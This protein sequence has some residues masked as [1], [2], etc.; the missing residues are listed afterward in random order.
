MYEDQAPTLVRVVRLVI[1]EAWSAIFPILPVLESHHLFGHVHLHWIT[2]GQRQQPRSSR[3]SSGRAR[4]GSDLTTIRGK[5]T[6]AS[7]FGLLQQPSGRPEM[8][9]PIAEAVS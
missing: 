1:E 6:A 3:R 8:L 7:E 9:S 2:H 4:T 5:P